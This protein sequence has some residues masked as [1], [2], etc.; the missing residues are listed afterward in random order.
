MI[1]KMEKYW[2]LMYY[3]V[4]MHWGIPLILHDNMDSYVSRQK[5]D[6]CGYHD[7]AMTKQENDPYVYHN[8]SMVRQENDHYI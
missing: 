1:M 5:N 4:L 2:D 7:A 6:H 8:A 3:C